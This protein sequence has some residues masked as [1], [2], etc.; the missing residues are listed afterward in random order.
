ML[1]EILKQRD[2]VVRANAIEYASF[3]RQFT[4]TAVTVHEIFF[5]L[6]SRRAFRQMEEAQVVFSLNDVI[7]P[8]FED[9]KLA[10]IIRGRA[11]F[12]GVQLAIDD[13]LIGAAA[14]RLGLPMV[15]GNTGHFLAMKESGLQIEL[16][17]WRVP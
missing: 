13:C 6:E 4:F 15:T 11:R 1:S 17:N 2:P 7:L 12:A 3:H 8:T 16:E 5:G 9:Y 14:S 10:G